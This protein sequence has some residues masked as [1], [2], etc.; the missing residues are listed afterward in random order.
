MKCQTRRRESARVQ[1]KGLARVR[2]KANRFD[3]A[4]IASGTTKTTA[5]IAI[6]FKESYFHFNAIRQSSKG[7]A[8]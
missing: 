6:D 4:E 2:Y 8:H 5:S 1:G 7:V 3:V